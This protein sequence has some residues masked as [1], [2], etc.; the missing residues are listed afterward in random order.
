[1]KLSYFVISTALAISAVYSNATKSDELRATQEAGYFITC[2]I[3]GGLGNTDIVLW[4]SFA[5]GDS[6]LNYMKQNC[7]MNRGLPEVTELPSR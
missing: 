3:R 4:R 2:Y 5:V 7:Y 6:Q 1:M